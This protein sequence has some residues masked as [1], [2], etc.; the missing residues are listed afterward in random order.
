MKKRSFFERVLE[1]IPAGLSYFVI[2][3]PVVLSIFAP[4]L[5]VVFI[6]AFVFYW[7]LNSLAMGGHLISAVLHFQY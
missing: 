2:F 5:L 3:I 1:I 7:L 4:H 6:V